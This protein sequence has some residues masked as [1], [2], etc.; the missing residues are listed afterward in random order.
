MADAATDKTI[1]QERLMGIVETMTM[2][3]LKS[4][5]FRKAVKNKTVPAPVKLSPGVHK[6]R[7]SEVMKHLD[8]LPKAE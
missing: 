3:D 1:H 5:A 6:W 8:S 2:Y 4:T 7:Y